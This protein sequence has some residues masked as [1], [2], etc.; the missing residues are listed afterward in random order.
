M[1]YNH[2]E[3]T[4]ELIAL[5]RAEKLDKIANILQNILDYT[6][7]GTEL[8]MALKFNLEQIPQGKVSAIAQQRIDNLIANIN[9]LLS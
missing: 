6:F 7:S 5:L 2:L 4:K 3:E 9:K 1:T 8:I